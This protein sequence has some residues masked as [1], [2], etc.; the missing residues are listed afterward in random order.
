MVTEVYWIQLYV[1]GSRVMEKPSLE[2]V[3]PS[4]A[5]VPPGQCF[6]VGGVDGCCR[7]LRHSRVR[8]EPVGATGQFLWIRGR[9][10]GLIWW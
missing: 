9:G 10:L 7:H 3:L 2:T 5:Q 8:G 6:S 4:K 1:Y